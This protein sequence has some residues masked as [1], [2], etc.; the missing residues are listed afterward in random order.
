MGIHPA[1]TSKLAMKGRVR[2]VGMWYQGRT[3]CDG[4]LDDVCFR[5]D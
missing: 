2:T 3:L 5:S 4:C 1:Y